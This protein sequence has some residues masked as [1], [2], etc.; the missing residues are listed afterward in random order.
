MP[1]SS[2]PDVRRD[3]RATY[4]VVPNLFEA[5]CAHNEMPAAAFMAADQALGESCL[6]RRE[7]QAVLLELARY[8]CSRYDAVVHVHL[9]R[10]A[11][12][13]DDVIER[14]LAGGGTEDEQF[15]ALVEA[16]RLAC[17]QRG[18]LAPEIIRDLA[19]RGVTRGKLYEIFALVGL[20]TFTSFAGHLAGVEVDAPLRSTES[21]MKTV[22]DRP[23]T[24]KRQRLFV[25]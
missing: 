23:D 12:L 22:P 21:G 4:G 25:G 2:A 7:Q 10:E 20:K 11:G 24:M 3:A 5:L 6:S 13:D 8:F 18:W 9:A 1:D 15:G 16:A 14:V 17:D 19:E